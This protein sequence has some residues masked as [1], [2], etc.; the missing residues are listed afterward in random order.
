MTRVVIFEDHPLTAL[1]LQEAVEA[2]GATVCGIFPDSRSARAV[3]EE[4]RPDFA[5]VD[6]TLLDGATGSEIATYLAERGCEI[7]VHSGDTRVHPALGG[8]PHMFISKPFSRRD[9]T[10][11]LRPSLRSVA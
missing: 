10:E 9:L 5:I 11:V 7:I 6:L 8:I 2:T 1:D 3:A 4:I